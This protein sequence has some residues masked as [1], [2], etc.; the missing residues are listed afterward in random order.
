QATASGFR[1]R[2]KLNPDGTPT[3]YH[4]VYRRAG[5]AECEDLPGCGSSTAEGGPL[6]GETQQ[7]VPAIEVTGLIPG[8]T[9][10]YSLIAEN[11]HGTGRGGEVAFTTAPARIIT[12]PG[13]GGAK[14][15]PA[16]PRPAPTM[17]LG[18]PASAPTLAISAVRVL[19][20]QVRLTTRTSARGVLSVS[21][22]GVSSTSR[23]LAAGVHRVHIAISTRAR[24][25]LSEHRR[26]LLH[27][28]LR[29]A[30]R[31]LSQTLAVRL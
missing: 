11:E 23:P 18:A 6:T 20:E 8:Q 17:G 9:Y 16:T 25:S 26:T 19:G 21:G 28:R 12:L 13:P 14:G 10:I 1:L 24:T 15:F 22:P 29:T 5:E 30:S 4:F 7:E 31:T 3:S 2:G 27:L